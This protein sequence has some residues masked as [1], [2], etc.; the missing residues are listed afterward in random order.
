MGLS[1]KERRE[2]DDLERQL[3]AVDPEIDH[4]MSLLPRQ[5][6]RARRR[7]RHPA[8][9]W[10]AIV[11][12]A[13]A[14]IVLLS[15]SVIISFVAFLLLFAG[16]VTAVEAERLTLVRNFLTRASDRAHTDEPR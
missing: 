16:V 7:W 3:A 13:I 9:V 10:A 15:V 2:L 4:A 14:T 12:G 8:F 6:E 11:V 1:R 5:F